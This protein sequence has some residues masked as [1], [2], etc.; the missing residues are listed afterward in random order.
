MMNEVRSTGELLDEI[1]VISIALFFA[2]AIF[3]AIFGA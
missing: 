1:V 3:L 2:M